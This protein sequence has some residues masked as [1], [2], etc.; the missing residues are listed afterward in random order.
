MTVAGTR[1]TRGDRTSGSHPAPRRA[2]RTRRLAGLA[3]AA[4]LL[5]SGCGGLHPGAA[6]VVGSTTIGHE[7]VDDLAAALCTANVKGAQA[8]GAPQDFATRGTRQGALQ[9]LLDARLSHLFGEARGVE[10]DSALVSQA[11]AQNEPLIQA[12]PAEQRDAYREALREYASGQ[13]MLIEI[14]RQSLREQGKTGVTDDEAL[15]EGQRLRQKF[16]QDLDIEVDPR[17][18]DYTNGT[19]KPGGSSLSVAESKSARAGDTAQ[20]GPA[21]VAALPASQRCSSPS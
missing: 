11:L 4:A 14:G 20:P 15:A 19:L 7:S 17:Y 1:R 18:G 16:V 5:L 6:A 12:L 2:S 13:V 21:F 10:P 8:S 3:A 9:I